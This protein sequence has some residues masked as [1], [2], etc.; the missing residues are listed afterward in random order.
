MSLPWQDAASPGVGGL[1][2]RAGAAHDPAARPTS[3]GSAAVRAAA[4]A[5]GLATAVWIRASLAAAGVDPL[6]TG[7]LFGLLLASIAVAGG[8]W[9]RWRPSVPGTRAVAGSVTLG[10]AGGVGL[11]VVALA[12][13]LGLDGLSAGHAV[14]FAPWAVVT[15]VVA[16]G[17]EAV[18]RGALFE[19]LFAVAGAPAAL[20]GTALAFALLHVPLYGSAVVPL[21]LAVG[22]CLGGLRFLSGGV[23]APAIAHA[24]ADLATWWL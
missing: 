13:R 19:A 17:E 22:L 7:T 5:V 1:R 8:R 24:V 4:L 3:P 18:L 10:L 14:P 21:D 12:G 2:P 16:T 9:H 20:L 15:V 23:A 6:L 11:V